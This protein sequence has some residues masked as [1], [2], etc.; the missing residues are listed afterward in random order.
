MTTLHEQGSYPRARNAIGCSSIRAVFAFSHSLQDYPTLENL[1]HINCN[2]LTLRSLFKPQFHRPLATMTGVTG[3]TVITDLK[4]QGP[5]SIHDI[6]LEHHTADKRH[7]IWKHLFRFDPAAFRSMLFLAEVHIEDLADDD[8]VVTDIRA[9]GFSGQG[10]GWVEQPFGNCGLWVLREKYKDNKEKAITDVDLLYGKDAVDPRPN[11]TLKRVPFRGDEV[12]AARF[13]I[14]RGTLR[15]KTPSPTLRMNA[16]GKFKIVQIADT[17]MVTGV[18]VCKDAIDAEGKPLRESDA[19]PLTVKFI[20]EVLDREKPDLVILTGDNVHHNVLDTQ[21]ALFKVVAPII[22]RQIPWAVVFG[23]HDDEGKWALSRKWCFVFTNLHA[24]K[25]LAGKTQMEI[26]QDLPY[27]LCQS[28]PANV[29]GVGNYYLQIIGAA[30]S[31]RPVAT[32]YLLDSHGQIPNTAKVN[33]NPDYEPIKQGQVGWFWSTSQAL[34]KSREASG[35]TN[36]FHT[37]IVFQHIPLPEFG[38]PKLIMHAGCRGE[39]TEGPSENTY[40]YDALVGAGVSAMA[41]GHDHVNDFCALLPEEWRKK[42][43]A[44]PWLYYGG[45]VGFGAYCE[46]DGKRCWR[47]ARVWE[48]SAGMKDEEGKGEVRT[49]IRVEYQKERVGEIVLMENDMVQGGAGDC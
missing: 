8:L 32:I 12:L 3:H 24:D 38:D 49:W 34:R 22:K 33:G 46:Y 26:F 31:T 18:G 7:S 9:G 13:T 19:D 45:C 5:A 11:W 20:G 35:D 2:I 10:D 29:D 1:L 23:N 4:I 28:G 25:K 44:G 16:D 14:R 30:P 21:T 47:R 40:F 36:S 39:P 15:P 43:K 41:C 37:S 6:A 17:H 27:S 48:L 42:G